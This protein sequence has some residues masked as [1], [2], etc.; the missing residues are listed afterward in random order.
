MLF[1]G[2]MPMTIPLAMLA[3]FLTYWIDRWLILRVYNNTRIGMLDGSLVAFASQIL[4]YA[5][6]FH[7]VL[8]IYIYGFVCRARL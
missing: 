3:I 6:F 1:A 2:T 8:T 4:P 7:L 5:I